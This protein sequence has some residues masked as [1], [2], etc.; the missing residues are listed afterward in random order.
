METLQITKA[1]ALETYENGT[2]KQK[3]MLEGLFG[4]STFLKKVTDRI[5]SYEDACAEL[6]ITP[7]SA[8]NFPHQF[9]KSPEQAFAEHQLETIVGALNG[10]WEPNWNN[11]SE[12]KYYNYFDMRGGFSFDACYCLI[13]VSFVSSRL[14]FKSSELAVYAAK[15]FLNLYKSYYTL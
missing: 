8:A 1:N 10:G 3:E 4:K 5:K 11:S 15:Q 2:K 12:Y 9:R 14:C 7:L 6:K 13:S